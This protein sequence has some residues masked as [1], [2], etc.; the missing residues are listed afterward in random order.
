MHSC[1]VET[2]KYLNLLYD[3]EI[4]KARSLLSKSERDTKIKEN[5]SFKRMVP[6]EARG[7]CIARWWLLLHHYGMTMG[8][9]GGPLTVLSAKAFITDRTD[10]FYKIVAGVLYLPH[11]EF[12][13]RGPWSVNEKAFISIADRFMAGMPLDDKEIK[14]VQQQ[15]TSAAKPL[16]R[17]NKAMLSDKY[18]NIIKAFQPHLQTSMG[19]LLSSNPNL[20]HTQAV[21]TIENVINY[22]FSEDQ[23]KE[24]FSYAS[25]VVK[26]LGCRQARNE[27]EDFVD[28]C[29]R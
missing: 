2:E 26:N 22:K 12:I 16:D 25:T 18:L 1:F 28:L 6:V 10:E 17:A 3:E 27:K 21:P 20:W 15:F 4:S 24:M 13:D 8:L 9:F 23:K 19:Y 29:S 14:R 11:N 5:S 7:A